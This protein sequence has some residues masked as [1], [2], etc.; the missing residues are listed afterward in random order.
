MAIEWRDG[1]G[2]QDRS[3][4]GFENGRLVA[5]VARYDTHGGHWLAFVRL[6]RVEGRHRTAEDAMTA[7]EQA[8]H[9]DTSAN[10]DG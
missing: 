3:R 4:R 5:T 1:P 9:G 10:R 6:E 7:A 2:G 8:H